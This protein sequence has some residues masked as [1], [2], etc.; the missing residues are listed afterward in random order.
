MPEG[1]AE[2]FQFSVGKQAQGF[3]VDVIL[4]E[5]F[6]ILRQPELLEPLLDRLHLSPQ[7]LRPGRS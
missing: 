3:K 1:D 5:D 2:L 4:G 6:R 7:R